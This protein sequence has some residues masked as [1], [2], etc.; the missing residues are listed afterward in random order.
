MGALKERCRNGTHCKGGTGKDALKKRHKSRWLSHC[1][2]G[3]HRK[4]RTERGARMDSLQE[5]TESTETEGAGEEDGPKAETPQR[6][7]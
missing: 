2:G 1:M 7:A 3:G 6:D 4:R 5:G